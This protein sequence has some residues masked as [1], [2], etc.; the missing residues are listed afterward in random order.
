MGGHTVGV[1]VG[2]DVGLV[3]ADPSVGPRAFLPSVLVPAHCALAC[4]VGDPA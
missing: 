1:F 2:P 4:V 3:R